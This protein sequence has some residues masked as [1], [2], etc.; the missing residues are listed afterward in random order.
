M[1]RKWFRLDLLDD[2]R[3]DDG[4]P[5]PSRLPHLIPD[6]EHVAPLAIPARPGLVR[7]KDDLLDDGVAA[8]FGL[9]GGQ[10]DLVSLSFDAGRFT[11]AEAALWLARRGFAPLLL[12]PDAGGR[13]P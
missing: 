2:Q 12:V 8:V 7:R 1:S 13:S 6:K 11:P 9:A 4:P 3:A 10:A 5:V